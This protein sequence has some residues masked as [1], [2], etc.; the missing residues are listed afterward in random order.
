[1]PFAAAEPYNYEG[2]LL[3][4]GTRKPLA[5]TNIFILPHAIKATTDESGRFAIEE[6]PAGDF[7]WSIQQTGYKKFEKNETA[8]ENKSG[9]KIFLEKLA[10]NQYETVV[11]GKV[12]KRDSG[13]Q[14]LSQEEFLYTP[15]AR[16]DPVI[17]LENLPGAGRTDDAQVLIQG[18]EP[19]ETK[20]TL[21]GHEIP[22]VFHFIGLTS[23]VIPEGVES[24]DFLTAGYGPEYGGALGGVVGL[25]TRDPKTDR[26]HLTGFVDAFHSG[27]LI[28]GPIDKKSSFSIGG[29]Y[30]YLGHVLKAVLGDRE[31]TNLTSA[32]TYFDVVGTYKYKLS[33]KDELKLVAVSSWDDLRLLTKDG[34]DPFFNGNFHFNTNFFRAI[35]SWRHEFNNDSAFDVSVA[36][37]YDSILFDQGDRFGDFDTIATT[38]RSEYSKRLFSPWKGFW[39]IDAVFKAHNFRTR[40]P[41]AILNGPD[42]ESGPISSSSLIDTTFKKKEFNLAGYWRNELRFEQFEKWTFLPNVRLDYFGLTGETL[43]QPRLEARY[44]LLP[45]VRLRSAG[46]LYYQAPQVLEMDSSVG[47]ADLTASRAI[48]YTLGADVDL[49]RGQ[50]DGVQ[51]SIA[52]FYKDL[53]DLVISSSALVPRNGFIEPE[54][55]N[56]DGSGYIYGSEM[57]IKNQWNKLNLS[58]A[59]TWLRSRQKEP[60][61]GTFPSPSDQTHNI[62]L[63]SAYTLGKWTLSARYRYVTGNPF[64]PVNG[65]TYDSDYDVF[66]PFFGNKLSDRLKAFSQLDVRLDRKWIFKNWILTAYLDIQNVTNR[67]NVGTVDYSFDYSEVDGESGIPILPT[68]GLRGEF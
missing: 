31:D 21:N 22:I 11:L 52:G 37:G 36:A 58:L 41:Q 23:I 54:N 47:N 61:E 35:P 49:R 62:N 59:Y 30:S 28:E 51:F 67:N 19:E 18:A 5:F 43:A 4:K 48:H 53:D 25:K 68:I 66:V 40:V 20:Y 45:E 63:I 12:Q 17:A 55:Y 2:Q 8:T 65:S 26:F 10:Y 50:T 27:V 57:Q 24:V 29:R 13:T 14:T 32:P 39:G 60:D 1:M 56:N 34:E 44:Q 38:L 42:E 6:I 9:I 7:Q 46:G 3:E 33:K 15:G 64:T 16:G